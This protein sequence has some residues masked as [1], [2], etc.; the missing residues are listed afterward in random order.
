M[1]ISNEFKKSLLKTLHRE[2]TM[3]MNLGAVHLQ[4]QLLLKTKDVL[5]SHNDGHFLSL[6]L[7]SSLQIFFFP[8]M[9]SPL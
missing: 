7:N 2:M 6:L 8:N 5:K 9:I 1:G 4:D 3:T